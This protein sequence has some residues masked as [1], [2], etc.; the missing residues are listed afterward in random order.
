MSAV[1][2]P[3]LKLETVLQAMALGVTRVRTSNDGKNA[4]ILHVNATMGYEPIPG[5]IQFMKEA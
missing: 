1:A 4:P 3:A 5:W 2:P